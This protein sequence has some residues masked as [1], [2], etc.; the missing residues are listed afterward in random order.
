[1]AGSTFARDESSDSRRLR[2]GSESRRS[3]RRPPCG[4]GITSFL[5]STLIVDPAPGDLTRAGRCRILR[6]SGLGGWGG[7][8]LVPMGVGLATPAASADELEKSGRV[9]TGAPVDQESFAGSGARP[10][11]P[12]RGTFVGGR[13]NRV[14]RRVSERDLES[15]DLARRPAG[16]AERFEG[17]GGERAGLRDDRTPCDER[18]RGGGGGGAGLG[19]LGNEQRDR[20]G[21]AL[22]RRSP[23]HG[24][25]DRLE[26]GRTRGDDHDR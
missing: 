20:Y 15:S 14:G 3:T 17:L 24:Q 13:L 5:Q 4:S 18:P 11:Q 1:M 26:A 6:R 8:G 10:A 12:A 22:V 2:S 23:E 9:S 25:G 7:S 19:G 16:A 21:P